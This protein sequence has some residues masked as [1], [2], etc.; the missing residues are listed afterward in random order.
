M[1]DTRSVTG[2]ELLRRLHKLGRRRGVAVAVDASLG[3][4]DHVTVW[5]GRRF[6]I[7]GD[8][9]ELKAGTLHGM[10]KQLGFRLEDL[11]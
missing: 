1:P 7:L 4:G 8:R 2:R 10:L 5:Y 9:G 6:T 11:Y 3:K